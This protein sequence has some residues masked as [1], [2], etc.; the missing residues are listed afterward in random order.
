M[1]MKKLFIL[2][3]CLMVLSCDDTSKVPY[4]SQTKSESNIKIDGRDCK[5]HRIEL[6]DYPY[7]LLHTTCSDGSATDTYSLGKSGIISN[8]SVPAA[9][10]STGR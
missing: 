10:S 7:L 1:K 9:S 3:F 2:G 5:I 8:G 6:N 4:Q